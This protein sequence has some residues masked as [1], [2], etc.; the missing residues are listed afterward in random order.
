MTSTQ[1]SLATGRSPAAVVAPRQQRSRK[2]LNRLLDAAE[3][4]L[5]ERDF[6]EITVADIVARADSCVG[7]FYARFPSKDS[8]V[9]A[10]LERYHEEGYR[11]IARLTED[12]TWQDMT[13]EEKM[14]EYVRRLV[15][16]CRRRRGLLRLRL[17]RRITPG[18]TVLP[19]EGQR[20]KRAV[21]GLRDLFDGAAHE[22]TRPDRDAALTFALRVVD[23]VASAAILLDDVST[24][25]GDLPDD[26]LVDQLAELLMA[27]LTRPV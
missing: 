7:S 17:R 15:D 10:L 20:D 22:I 18:Q 27:Y 25:F 1:A 26:R 2:T 11:E 5:D 3:K 14:R 12:S 13:L 16:L 23:S 19:D 24:S 6:E 8:L 9:M 4:L 21:A